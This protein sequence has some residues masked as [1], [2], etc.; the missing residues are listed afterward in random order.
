MSSGELAR[1]VS[2]AVDGKLK[3][4]L[5]EMIGA[6]GTEMTVVLL[7]GILDSLV[8]QARING[9][10]SDEVYAAAVAVDEIAQAEVKGAMQ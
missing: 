2:S 8:E 9:F 5:A 1:L 3:P 4:L 7:R 6:I 10:W